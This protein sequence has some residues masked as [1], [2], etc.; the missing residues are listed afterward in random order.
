MAAERT[1][2]DVLVE[3]VDWLVTVDGARRVVRDAAVAIDA[4]RFVA[5]GKS[6]DVTAAYEGRATLDGRHAVATPGLVDAHL[7]SSFQLS[8]GL[9]DEANAREFLIRRMYPY[10]AA[11]RAEDVER[12]ARLAAREMLLHGTTC[13]VDPGN[14]HPEATVA[15]VAPTG[16]RAVV[17]RSAFDLGDSAFGNVPDSMVSTPDSAAKEADALVER[18]D[19][20]YEGRVRA[21]VS[22]R[23]LNNSSDE[24]IRALR[25]VAA[26]HD[27]VLQTHACFNYSTHD[28]SVARF[29]VPEVERLAALGALG[30]RTLLVHGGWLEPAE[31]S[32]LRE[33]EA[34]V[35]A[36]PSSSM[37]N[38]YGNVRMG[39]LP[40]L[41]EL[42]VNV[43]LGSDHAC[44]GPVD[45]VRE[46]FLAACGHKE[47]RLNPRV[48]PPETVLEM[49]TVNGAAATGMAEEIGAVEVGKRADLVLFD[50]DDPSW[51]PL[52][53]PVSNLVYSATGRTARH[54]FVGG[55]HVVADGRLTRVDEDELLADARA[56]AADLY[57]RIGGDALVRG[58]WPVS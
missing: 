4:G 30:P 52:Y 11:L 55:E 41:L 56:G 49:A 38:G 53:N 6:G 37:H 1:T 14:N 40:E 45:L 50:T 43:A 42:G 15:G 26:T 25:D 3:H 19:G 22:F 54:V 36:A 8:R 57:A 28:A 29:G 21:S 5:V 23:G 58:R 32:I 9:A 39:V 10:E 51:L 35:A 47:V 16:I 48:M 31:V 17:A 18:H 44:S 46:M 7:H 24:L 2:V 33:H 12:S 27:V 20:T 34:S 13:F